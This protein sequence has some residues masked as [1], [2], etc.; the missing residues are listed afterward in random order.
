MSKKRYSIG[1][2]F[3]TLSARAVLVDVENG[4]PLPYA[5]V[6]YYPHAVMTELCGRPR[7]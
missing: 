1:L 3:G 2:D 4:A 5:S 7:D 6:F